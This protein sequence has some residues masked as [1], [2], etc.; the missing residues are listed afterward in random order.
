M[1][2]QILKATGT[3]ETLKKLYRSFKICESNCTKTFDDCQ[4][5]NDEHTKIRDWIS[6]IKSENAYMTMCERIELDKYPG[7]GQ[8]VL[9]LPEYQNWSA[10]R[11]D[12][13][14]I[15]GTGEQHNPTF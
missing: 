3:I 2:A 1:L 11:S 5:V 13:L 8:W 14:W 12:I 4:K 6:D 15:Q 9:D 7:C 10:G